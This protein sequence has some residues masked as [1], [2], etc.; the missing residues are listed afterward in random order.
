[1]NIDLI[2]NLKPYKT[3][4]SFPDAV[5]LCFS[6]VKAPSCLQHHLSLTEKGR[7]SSPCSWFIGPLLS[8]SLPPVNFTIVAGGI[9]LI[10]MV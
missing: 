8:S 2:F 1:M 4:N 7:T 5:F 10:M 3:I 6:I 9:R